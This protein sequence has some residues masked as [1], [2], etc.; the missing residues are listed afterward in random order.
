MSFASFS[1]L[2][3]VSLLTNFLSWSQVNPLSVVSVNQESV[4]AQR[5]VSQFIDAALSPLLS[6]L[7]E[8]LF[9]K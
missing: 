5:G 1:G 4:L 6:H 3:Q 7:P 8:V 2:L 9:H